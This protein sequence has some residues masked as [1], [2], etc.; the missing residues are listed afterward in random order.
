MADGWKDVPVTRP[1]P[2]A[3]LVV[4]VLA[5]TACTSST[6]P[7]P[8]GDADPVAE[9]STCATP[10]AASDAVLA[11]GDL[12]TAPTVSFDAPLE[13]TRTERTVVVAGE[14]AE[15]ERGAL[16]T[17]EFSVYNGT[18]GAVA[19]GTAYREEG[20]GMVVVDPERL[21]PGLARTILC[22][23]EGSRVVGV[24]PPEEAFGTVGQ[25]DLGIEPG[26]SVVFVVD[27]VEVLPT[28]AQGETVELPEDFPELD[29]AFADDGRPTIGIPDADP[30]TQLRIATLVE[31]AGP[32]VGPDDEFTVQYQGVN[33]RTGEIFD[34]TWGA[35]PRSFTSVIAGFERAVVGSTVGSRVVAVIPPKQGYGETG[36]AGAGIEGADTIVFVIDILATTPPAP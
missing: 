35:A 26:Q 31:G 32:V 36:N 4:A 3:A 30:P 33:W 25:A 29:L 8:T 9:T 14:G 10:G 28:R 24:V 21:V 7:A 18:T 5:V 1:L 13:V 23:S 20:R 12:G 17:L 16:I 2:A 27:V 11:T 22:S 19:T 6:P 15:V 34:E